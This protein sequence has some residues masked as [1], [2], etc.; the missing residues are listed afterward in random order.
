MSPETIAGIR[1]PVT[2]SDGRKIKPFNVLS[3][4]RFRSAAAGFLVV[5]TMC[6]LSATSW[7]HGD[8][9]VQ[10]KAVSE[11]IDQAPTAL[12][13]LKRG[14]LHQEH[15]DFVAALADYDRAAQLDSQLDAI[16][17]SRARTLFKVR[18]LQPAREALDFYLKRKPAHAEGYLLRARVLVGLEEYPA[19]IQDFNR[20]LELTPQ[21]LPECFLE[22]AEALV[23]SG[24]NPGAVKSLDEGT[25]RLGNLVTL[26][27][28]AIAIELGLDRHDAALA[29]V[30]RVM[31]SLQRKETWLTR[32][33]EI[34]EAAGRRE[35]AL[36]AYGAALAALEQLPAQHRNVKP[37]RELEAHLRQILGPDFR[38]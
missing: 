15:E 23:A 38:R 33:G 12:L 6:G 28:A 1:V 3:C 25:H 26:Q 8:L 31:T 21:P 16:A 5:M 14:E 34:L 4:F 9:D 11:Q 24:D 20:N 19:A 10:I 18:R 27:S 17:F 29:R 2:S 37:M 36:R 30:D 7:A 22:R 32:R 13:Y 35:E